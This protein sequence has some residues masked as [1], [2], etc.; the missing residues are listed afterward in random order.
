M[1]RNGTFFLLVATAIGMTGLATADDWPR[2]RGPDGNAVSTD[3][4]PL[5]VEW[6]PKAN[7]DWK[8]DL[9]GPGVS[10][11][12]I[13][14]GKVFVTCYSGYGLD[15]E[16]PGDIDDLTR[17]L[18][19]VDLETGQTL[20]Q[21]DFGARQPEDPY[22]GIGVTAHGYA[23]HTP[24][25]DGEHVFVFF[26]K[27]GAYAFDMAGNEVWNTQLGDESDPFRWGSAAS[28][29]VYGDLVIVTAAAESQAIVGLDKQTGKEVW[30]QEAA[31][32]DNSWSTPS[33][34]EVDGQT[35]LVV[36]VAKEVWGLDP[37]TGK[38][39]WYSS[40][41]GAEQSHSSPTIRDGLIYLFTGRGGGSVA[42][43]PGGSGDV[44]ESAVAWT[45]RESGSFASPV[46]DD[47]NL[48][49][50]SRGVLTVVDRATGEK[51]S[52]LRLKGMKAGATRFGSLDYPSPII[53]DGRL[54]YL[55]GTGQTFVF[56]LGDEPEQLAANFVTTT[57]ETF[58]GTPA[59]SNGRIVLRGADALYCVRDKGEPVDPKDN[60]VPDSD[61]A[62]PR[63]EWTGRP[64][65]G[66]PGFG[67]RGEGRGAEGRGAEGRGAEGREGQ[68]GRG[69]FGRPGGER[70]GGGRPGEGR[71]G[72]EN[73]GGQ[74]DGNAGRGRYRGGFG[75]WGP[76]EDNR[77]Q[78][79]ERPTAAD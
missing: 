23:S 20:W 64:G 41:T 30:R 11:P 58:G 53:A 29:I 47:E 24:V 13:V 5:P 70:S 39:R 51:K 46:A 66:R 42:V 65:G 31:G 35:D 67:Q 63:P 22:T 48:Y 1:L 55:G 33:L 54:Y 19:C 73:A 52:Q 44:S 21:K 61:I 72:G 8:V 9:P 57:G 79:P 37:S 6:S 28:P 34:V 78:R 68:A 74:G 3:G 71:P 7:V 38:L 32:L 76:K 45:G 77:P 60:E 75:N 10:S 27:S 25:T 26:G 49:N 18:V 59:V 4:E 56:S 14:D 43:K 50:I 36:S 40:A 17:H 62:K 69:G 12:I 15:R 16:N 2:F